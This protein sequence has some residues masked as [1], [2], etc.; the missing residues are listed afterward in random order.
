MIAPGEPKQ[1]K[2]RRWLS[3]PP[4]DLHE[5]ERELLEEFASRYPGDPTLTA[6]DRRRL[7]R[8]FSLIADRVARASGS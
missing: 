7:V 2:A 4:I 3:H 1:E 5:S 8:Q 6:V